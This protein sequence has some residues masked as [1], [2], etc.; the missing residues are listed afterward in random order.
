M[1]GSSF[2]NVTVRP[3]ASNSA[4]MDEAAK[5]LP[6]LDTTPPVT[7]I[8]LGIPLLR[9]FGVYVTCFRRLFFNIAW[10]CRVQLVVIA[11]AR[12]LLLVVIPVPQILLHRNGIRR[13]RVQ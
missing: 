7:K 9:I 12:K 3:R 8:Y 10:R 2:I 6:R 13:L 5:P 4:P 1:Y 11:C